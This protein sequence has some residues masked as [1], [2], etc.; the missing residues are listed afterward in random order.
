MGIIT[1]KIYERKLFIENVILNDAAAAQLEKYRRYKY[2]CA[3][4]LDNIQKVRL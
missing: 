2:V 1:S 3:S 4:D